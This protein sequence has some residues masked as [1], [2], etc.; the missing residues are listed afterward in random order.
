MTGKI[1]SLAALAS[2]IA[3]STAALAATY[4]SD[5][6]IGFTDSVGN[7]K[8]Y[9]L[10]APASITNGQQW[11]LSS[12]TT[13]FNV[14]NV[15]WGV[16]GTATVG[17]ART[18]WITTDGSLPGTIPSASRWS[19]INTAVGGIYVNFP[20]AGPGQSVSISPLDP[21]SWNQETIFGTGATQYRSVYQNPN[22]I[23]VTCAGFWRVVSPS[24]PP[25][26]VGTFCLSADKVLT[27]TAASAAPP[28]PT[29]S[30]SRNGATSTI[31]FL[32]SNSVTYTLAYT[33][34][35]GLT[36]P[37]SSWPTMAGAILGNNSVTN[38]TDTTTTSNRFYRVR[39]H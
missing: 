31:S 26:L 20:A 8:I 12:L 38:F 34:S 6:V 2:V 14:T 22:V 35:S 39:A 16:V 37:V 36:A 23:G 17:T 3:S 1:K 10:G 13:S 11:N 30:I 18:A 28:P 15:N 32:G 9:D 33:N 19:Q 27:F 25:V 5:L 21:Q 4:N 29:L 24:L 7:D